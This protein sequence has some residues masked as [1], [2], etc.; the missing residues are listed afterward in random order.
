M[1]IALNDNGGSI[2]AKFMEKIFQSF[3]ATKPSGEGRGLGLSLSSNLISK[4]HG[5]ELKV[6]TEEGVGTGFLIILPE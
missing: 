6:N 4:G 5:D 1:E 3:F 2:P